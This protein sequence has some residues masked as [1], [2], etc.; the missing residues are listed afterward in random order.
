M[1]RDASARRDAL[2]DAA[3]ACFRRG[4]YLVPLEDI[5]A[6][7]GVGRGT[8]YRNFRDRM[9]L[10]VAVFEREVERLERGFDRALPIEAAILAM[11]E[12]GAGTVGLFNRMAADMTFDADS[13]AAFEALSMRLE[14]VL[15]PLVA[16]AHADGSLAATVT[17]R[18]VTLA[19]RMIAGLMLPHQLPEDR[20]RIRAEALALIREGLR[21]R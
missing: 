19:M 2:I 4:G 21:P 1:R 11:A 13:R 8:L 18:Q 14:G 7:A 10:V 20:T 17:A 5:A 12:Q 16:R 15:Q 6:A 3:A 9:A